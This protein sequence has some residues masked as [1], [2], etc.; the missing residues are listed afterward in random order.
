MQLCTLQYRAPELLLGD[1]HFGCSVDLWSL[2]C[3]LGELCCGSLLFAGGEEI[4]VLFA[5]FKLLG[6]PGAGYLAGLPHYKS[7]FPNFPKPTWPPAGVPA[8]LSAVLQQCLE[9]DPKSRISASGVRMCIMDSTRMKVIVDKREGGQGIATILEECIEPRLLTFLQE[10][11][12]LVKMI[13]KWTVEAAGVRQCLKTPEMKLGLKYEEGGHITMKPP[14]CTL[15]ATLDMSKP[16][17]CKR[18]GMFASAFRQRNRPQFQQ[19]GKE[20]ASRIREFPSH[21]Q[22]NENA[23][24]F[25]KDDLADTCFVYSVVQVRYILMETLLVFLIYFI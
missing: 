10:D 14:E 2:G 19:I 4:E 5:A 18:V 8:E 1:R 11:P 9:L 24:D 7:T 6:T 13:R 15:M 12:D 20:I 25:L 22:Q 16:L 3:V 21:L 23:Q 17:S